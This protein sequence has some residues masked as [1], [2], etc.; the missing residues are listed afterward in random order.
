MYRGMVENGGACVVMLAI[1]STVVAGC[2]DK[3][4]YR[5]Y[6]E[7]P[8][9]GVLGYSGEAQLEVVWI[10][11]QESGIQCAFVYEGTVWHSDL[12]ARAPVVINGVS[13]DLRPY[14]GTRNVYKLGPDGTVGS[15][16]IAIDEVI[17]LVTS[18]QGHGPG[19]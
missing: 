14:I 13:Y 6:R 15:T 2:S 11:E 3:K 1:L 12:T 19:P 4:R 5:I 16:R 8:F 9:T 18:G 7:G 10:E 17:G